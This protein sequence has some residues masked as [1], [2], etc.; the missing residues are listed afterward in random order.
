MIIVLH[1]VLLSCLLSCTSTEHKLY[2][3]IPLHF[4]NEIT[5]VVTSSSGACLKVVQFVATP[6]D[7]SLLGSCFLAI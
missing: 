6:Q 5:Q 4:G 7:T 2:L 3:P 1:Y